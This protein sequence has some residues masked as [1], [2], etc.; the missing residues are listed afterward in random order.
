MATADATRCG[1]EW[2]AHPFVEGEPTPAG[3]Q[4]EVAQIAGATALV[5]R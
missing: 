2:S 5:L 4:V 3:E 1:E